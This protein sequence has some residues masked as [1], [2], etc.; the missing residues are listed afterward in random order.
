MSDSYCRLW[1]PSAVLM[2]RK[3]MLQGLQL[4]FPFASILPSPDPDFLY[5]WTNLYQWANMLATW[6]EEPTHWK[7]PWCSERVKAGG[8]GD[9]RGWDGW[10]ASPTQWTWVWASSGSWWWTRRPGGLQSMGSQRVGDDSAIELNWA[11]RAVKAQI[12]CYAPC[13]R[14]TLVHKETLPQPHTWFADGPD[15]TLTLPHTGRCQ[16]KELQAA[17]T[18]RELCGNVHAVTHETGVCPAP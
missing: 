4:L 11:D 16:L 5:H 6:C 1:L 14:V 3:H 2:G 15:C 12:P 17:Y 13:R 10:M 7:R 9:D 18:H 8:E